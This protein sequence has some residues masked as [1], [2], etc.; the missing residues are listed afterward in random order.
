M[1]KI[2]IVALSALC[3]SSLCFGMRVKMQKAV[4]EHA[5]LVEAVSGGKKLSSSWFAWNLFKHEERESLIPF[6]LS[7][8]E[9]RLTSKYKKEARRLL[10]KFFADYRR[11]QK[12]IV[13]SEELATHIEELLLKY[14][15]LFPMELQE[16]L[17]PVSTFLNRAKDIEYAACAKE[18][19]RSLTQKDKDL[20]ELRKK[21]SDNIKHTYDPSR[22]VHIEDCSKFLLIPHPQDKK[23]LKHYLESILNHKVKVLISLCSPYEAKEII[24]FWNGV[25]IDGLSVEKVSEQVIFQG[26]E[27]S[28]IRDESRAKQVKDQ[29]SFFPRIVE[30][31]IKVIRGS[32]LHETT[33][34]HYENWPDHQ[35]APDLDALNLLFDR[36]DSLLAHPDDVCMLN[37]KA[38]IGRSGLF[39][40]ADLGRKRLERLAAD[41]VAFHEMKMSIVDLLLEGRRFRPL[42]SPN[43]VQLA[44]VLEII[45][46]HYEE[47]AS[48]VSPSQNL[49]P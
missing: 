24:P 20:Y 35:E 31:K 19:V 14:R 43:P 3:C 22:I 9:D 13:L 37:C 11:L 10:Y 48:R 45:G 7:Q 23:H 34:L 12:E 26:R 1:S 44:Q 6:Y 18:V 2:V 36:K 46:K 25:E 41:G 33:H 5:H 42:L 8:L 49:S 17:I 28:V 4:L 27:P 38:T 29:A 30:R 47:L 32:E 39:F 40:L 16:F 15:R 21:L